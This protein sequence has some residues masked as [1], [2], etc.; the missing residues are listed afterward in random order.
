M[1]LG[2]AFGEIRHSAGYIMNRRDILKLASLG[3]LAVATPSLLASSARQ[4][5]PIDSRHTQDYLTRIRHPNRWHKGD[6]LIAKTQRALLS[7][8]HKKL[9]KIYRLVGYRKFNIIS[10]DAALKLAK[11]TP[12][13]GAFDQQE[14]KL[15]EQLFYTDANQY[16]FVGEKPVKALT[17][18]IKRND[19]SYIRGS[20]HYL[21]KGKP[22]QI[23]QLI[24][25]EIGDTIVLTSGVR[26]VTKQM[27]LF[28][29]KADRYNGNLSL[30][31]RSIAP[32]GYS[33]HGTGDFD[34]GKRGWGR[35]NFT[36]AFAETDEY[37]KL[38][39]LGYVSLR[40][41]RDNDLGVRF[42]PWHI[43]MDLWTTSPN[44]TS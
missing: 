21:F 15:L 2:S 29:S 44:H 5:M 36:A 35:K 19:V 32:P 28:I 7:S 26:G 41:P 30:A 42:E 33:F 39:E 8:T 37:K 11:H 3:S 20:G 24:K 1:A 9:G 14:I 12:N 13:I 34:I 16:G 17:T 22:L 43:K 4:N 27:Y 40:Y 23:Y 38:S 25:K 31:S 10:F 18:R 6:V